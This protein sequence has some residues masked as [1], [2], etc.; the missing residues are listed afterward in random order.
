MAERFHIHPMRP[1]LAADWLHFFDHEAFAD[2]PRWASCY[3]QFPSADH[4]ARPWKTRSAEENRAS[5]C[6]RLADGREQGVIAEVDGRIIGWC[7]AGA[8]RGFSIMDEA[9]EPL[10]DRLGAITCFVVAPA[11]RGQGVATALLD[12]ACALLRAQGF[13]AVDA[14]ARADAADPAALHTGPLS[15]Y[16]K[17]GFDLLR[18]VDGAQLLRRALGGPGPAAP[19]RTAA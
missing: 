10:A 13:E 15:M 19:L 1:D 7:K 3:C 5:A 9:P 2:N 14:W 11:W 16:R 4:A 12:G 8:W 18:E 17:A 6:Q